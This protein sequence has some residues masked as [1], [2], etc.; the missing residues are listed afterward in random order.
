MLPVAFLG[1]AYFVFLGIW[2]GL[3]GGPRPQ[4]RPWH[5]VPLAVVGVGALGSV[6]FLG[7]MATRQAPWCLLCVL[8]HALNGVLA[9]LVFLLR[10][11]FVVTLPS[12]ATGALHGRPAFTLT[13]RQVARTIAFS[14]LVIAALWLYRREHLG[15]R[16]QYAELLPYRALVRSLQTDPGFLLREFWAQPQE[17]IPMD[18]A[19]TVADGRPQ[20]VV[21]TDYQCDTCAC[22]ARRVQKQIEDAFGGQLA[23][24][25]RHHPLCA[26][27]NPQVSTDMHPQACAA[28][29]AAEAARLQGGAAAFGRMHE[30]LF[31]H[32]KQLSDD[33]YRALAV[34][35]GLD[36]E[37]LLRDMQGET[38]QAVVRAD[39]ELAR[40]LGVT[41]TPTIFLDGRRVPDICHTPAFWPAIAQAMRD[42]RVAA[43]GSNTSATGP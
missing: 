41:R 9:T 5:R 4:S 43:L 35:I 22:H 34:R 29:Y 39:V 28:A 31:A 20:L 27:C 37:R 18:R 12:A 24:A 14:L 19:E 8:V 15:F 42:E 33:V 13:G 30:L 36:G 11:R 17:T 7:L 6:F 3:L 10:G 32:R 21:F 26:A 25:V 16:R 2:F 40:T 38:V 1:L 23:L